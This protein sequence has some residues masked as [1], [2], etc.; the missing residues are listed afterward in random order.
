MQEAGR[1]LLMPKG[2]YAAGTTYTMLDLVNHS[3]A[4]WVCKKD[5]TGQEPSDSNTEYWQRFGTAVDLA[6]YLPK[7]GGEVKGDLLVSSPSCTTRKI[8][9]SSYGG[10]AYFINY[11]ANVLRQIDIVNPESDP[12]SQNALRYEYSD[13][14]GYTWNVFD[15]LHTGNKP[16]GTYTGNGDAEQRLIATGGIGNYLLL[17]NGADFFLVTTGGALHFNP[18]TGHIACIASDKLRFQ[19]GNLYINSNDNAINGNGFGFYYYV[20]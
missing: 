18:S 10:N 12:Y 7:T 1:I 3:G 4:S 11:G 19:D 5:C 6:N 14:N 17:S 8:K 15:I 16:T 2:D 13:D 20:P 9:Q